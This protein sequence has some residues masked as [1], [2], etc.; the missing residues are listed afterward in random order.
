MVMKLTADFHS[1]SRIIRQ[2]N[3]VQYNN[4]ARQC[5]HSYS[6]KAVSLTYS[7]CVFIALALRIQ[8][9]MLMRHIVICGLPDLQYEYFATYLKN[10]MIKKKKLWNIK[11]F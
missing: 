10:G 2:A 7:E 4:E 5:N 6:G 8:Q 9:V 1:L 3:Y 11:L